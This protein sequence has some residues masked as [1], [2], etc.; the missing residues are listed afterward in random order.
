MLGAPTPR[1]PSARITAEVN[2][3]K[4]VGAWQPKMHKCSTCEIEIHVSRCPDCGGNPLPSAGQPRKALNNYSLLLA[5]GLL[6]G[7]CFSSLGCRPP[8]SAGLV[9]FLSAPGD[10]IVEHR[11]KTA[12]RGSG[13]VADDIRLFEPCSPAAR[14][15][16]PSKRMAGWISRECSE[17]YCHPENRRPP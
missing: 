13:S 11:E 2:Y 14:T 4:G 5:P 17:G 12:E 15:P 8:G 3:G 6:V 1:N 16:A 10:A 7:Y 9:Y